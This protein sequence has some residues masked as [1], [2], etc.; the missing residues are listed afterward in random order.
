[1]PSCW[2]LMPGASEGGWDDVARDASSGEAEAE[3]TT[4]KETA[5]ATAEATPAACP[6]A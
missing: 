2:A 1:M 6:G 3:P 5:P 4:T